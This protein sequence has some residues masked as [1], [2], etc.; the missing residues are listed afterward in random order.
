MKEILLRP[1][2]AAHARFEFDS[3]MFLSANSGVLPVHMVQMAAEPFLSTSG[4]TSQLQV[5]IRPQ[6]PMRNINTLEVGFEDPAHDWNLWLSGSY[7]Q[8]FHFQNQDTWLNPIITPSSVVSTG[9]HIN[10]NR[11]VSI[12]GS[13]LVVNEASFNRS[14]KVPNVSVQL[15]SRFPLKQGFQLSGNWRISDLTQSSLSF[16]QDILQKN[17]FISIE[18]SHSIKASALSVGGGMDLILAKTTQGWVGNY[19][20]DD[21]LRGWLKYAF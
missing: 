2:F 14:S 16:I 18:F 12:E 13:V 3:G 5:N 8:P 19:Y 15:P 6:L 20:G 7:E 17:R 1:N 4:S 21:R 9:T 10:L 11:D